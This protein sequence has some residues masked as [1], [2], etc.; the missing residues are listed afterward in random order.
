MFP[1][2]IWIPNSALENYIMLKNVMVN[3]PSLINAYANLTPEQFRKAW[4][5]F[6][7]K[8]EN[9]HL[10]GYAGFESRRAEVEFLLIYQSRLKNPANQY[11]KGGVIAVGRGFCSLYDLVDWILDHIEHR[12]ILGELLTPDSP[13]IRL[14]YYL[15]QPQVVVTMTQQIL[16]LVL[17]ECF[18]ALGV[19]VET[20]P[21]SIQRLHGVKRGAVTSW[22]SALTPLGPQFYMSA[23][24]LSRYKIGANI[25]N[26]HG[27]LSVF[28]TILDRLIQ[29]TREY[30][31]VI[32]PD[33]FSIRLKNTSGVA[34]RPGLLD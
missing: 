27:I 32:Q 15:D 24:L 13:L 9:L 31:P 10:V 25:Q 12:L 14:D 2:K 3:F 33:D 29:P 22:L 18:E 34:G 16:K 28:L 23:M 21:T 17:A 6:A 1:Y 19:E 30:R 11:T 4:I 7:V 5:I 8:T 20:L 26:S